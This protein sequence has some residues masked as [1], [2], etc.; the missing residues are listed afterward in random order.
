MG[1]FCLWRNTSLTGKV[2]GTRSLTTLAPHSFHLLPI[3]QSSIQ[4]TDR[5]LLY[6]GKDVRIHIHRLAD[7]TV[8]EQFLDYLR[9]DAF[10]QQNG[11]CAEA[12]VVKAD[13]G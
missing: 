4:A 9:V 6:A 13:S 5:I 3:P 1:L 7:I 2:I 10:R 12:Q 8:A 11:C